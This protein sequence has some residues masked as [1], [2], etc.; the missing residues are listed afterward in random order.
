AADVVRTADVDGAAD[1]TCGGR[2]V[3]LAAAGDGAIR[4]RAV[5][6]VDGATRG[7]GAGAQPARVDEHRTQGPDRPGLIARDVHHHVAVGVERIVSE[8]LVPGEE[9]DVVVRQF[10]G[11]GREIVA[12]RRHGAETDGVGPGVTQGDVAAGAG[13]QSIAGDEEDALPARRRADQVRLD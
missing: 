1:L 11:R 6:E 9:R 12:R 3:H 13:R 7:Q 8:D 2:Q 5:A 10:D 4:S